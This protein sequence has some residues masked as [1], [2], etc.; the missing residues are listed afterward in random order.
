MLVDSKYTKTKLVFSRWLA[1]LVSVGVQFDLFKVGGLSLVS[2]V[3]ILYFIN[4][5]SFLQ[6]SNG[7]FQKYRKFIFPL[8]SF[9][10]LLTILNIINL[11]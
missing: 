4:C 6:K 9:I 3:I 10:I 5:I 8:A 2:A 1:F 7:F 11:N